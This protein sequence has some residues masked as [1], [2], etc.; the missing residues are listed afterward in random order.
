MRALVTGGAGFLGSHLCE[1]LLAEGAEVICLDN[2]F[3][4][5]RSNIKHLMSHPNFEVIRHDI[6]QPIWLEVDR[7]FHLACP[8]SPEHYLLNRVKPSKPNVVDTTN[9]LGRA[10]RAKPRVVLPPTG[11]FSE[12]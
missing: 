9:M 4:G 11:K 5:R 7:I 8:A 12:R 10:R 1:R 6:V 2:F 3:S